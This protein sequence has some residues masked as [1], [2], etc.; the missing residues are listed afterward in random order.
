[1]VAL[2]FVT[3][4][5]PRRLSVVALT[6]LESAVIAPLWPTTQTVKDMEDP[7]LMFLIVT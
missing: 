7:G 3:A 6:E 5:F 4:W 2:M 1:L